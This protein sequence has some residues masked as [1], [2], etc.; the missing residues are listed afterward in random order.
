MSPE[1]CSPLEQG[2]LGEGEGGRPPLVQGEP[3]EG[4]RS[5]PPL[6]RSEPG[7]GEGGCLPLVHGEAALLP[8]RCGLRLARGLRVPGSRGVRLR[9]PPAGQCGPATPDRTSAQAS[10]R[11]PTARGPALLRQLPLSGP[12]LEPLAPGRGQGRVASRR[13][14][15]PCRLSGDEPVPSSRA[16]GGLLQSAWHGR[17]GLI[18]NDKFCLSRFGRLRLSWW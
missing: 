3:G 1:T 17:D 12:D 2:K 16:G 4:K 15:Y 10:G 7:E 9:H 11:P 18:T 14:L 13:A 5:R 6:A 8:R